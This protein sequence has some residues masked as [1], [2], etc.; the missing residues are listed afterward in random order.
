M[1]WLAE[2]LLVRRLTSQLTPDVLLAEPMVYTLDEA[3][4][5][6]YERRVLVR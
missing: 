6:R 2:D 4:L 3:A 1:E 5:A